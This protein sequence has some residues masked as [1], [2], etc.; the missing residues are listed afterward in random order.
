[1]TRDR[2]DEGREES[3]ERKEK[4]KGED[5]RNYHQ[6]TEAISC[7]PPVIPVDG[8]CVREALKEVLLGFFAVRGYEESDCGHRLTWWGGHKRVCVSVCL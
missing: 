3:V 5:R 6:V 7:L 8:H 1:M 2:D 4:E